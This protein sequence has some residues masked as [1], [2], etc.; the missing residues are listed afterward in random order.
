MKTES[1]GQCIAIPDR[2]WRRVTLVY[3]L[4]ALI[5]VVF[6]SLVSFSFYQ[7]WNRAE[8][9]F[10][11]YYTAAVLVRKG[12][13]LRN[14]Y[15]W[16]WFQRQMNYVGIE[17]QLGGYV[18]QTPLTMLPIVPVANFPVQTAKRIWLVANLI[19]LA[20]TIW[21]LTRIT[22]FSAAAIALLAM[23]GY[24]SLHINLVLGQYYIFLLFLLTFAAHCLHRRHHRSAG[25]LLGVVFG[26][27]LYGGPFLLYFAAKRNWKAVAGML[28]GSLV[29]AAV[30]VSL[31]SWTDVAYFLTHVL[32]RALK[33]ETLDPYSAG[34]GTLS[35]LLRRTLMFEPELNPHPLWIAPW[36]FFF[37]QPLLT[38]TLLVFPLLA[39]RRAEPSNVGFAGFLIALLLVSPNTAS[40]TFILLLLPLSLLL[41]GATWQKRILL[42]ICYAISALPMRPSWSWLFPKVWCLLTLLFLAGDG[43]WQRLKWK[44]ALLSTAAVVFS[45]T[46]L[47]RNGL[48]N[49]AQE[50]GQNWEPFAVEHRAI[51]SSSPAV[52][53]SGVVYQ[54]IGSDRYILRWEHNGS[55]EPFVFSGEAFHPVALSPDGPIQ[56]ELVAHGVSTMN[57]LNPVRGKA[58]RS[59]AIADHAEEKAISPDRKWLAFTRPSSGTTQ[60]WL[61]KVDGGQLTRLTGGNCDSFAPAW[62]LDSK[63][64][65]FASDCGRGIGLPALYRARLRPVLLFPPAKS[66]QSRRRETVSEQSG[67]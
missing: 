57:L 28:A 7:G 23:A 27:K 37:L 41:P 65:L 39:L 63:S 67:G 6:A 44:P 43:Y 60:I 5:L 19:L 3:V 46:L 32:P 35:T 14:F 38:L 21:L 59:G 26:L 13:K 18:P 56:F 53:R 9:D 54:S 11:N 50:P 36:L 30:A 10:P 55:I 22:R 66:R 25:I 29:L 2:R 52:L 4:Q 24:G 48:V 61:R 62:E 12:E 1:D 45:A 20:A 16:T 31:F 40:Y 17:R 47:A 51:Y 58:V 34:T 33:G 42:L 49:Y 64:V 15:D 8:T